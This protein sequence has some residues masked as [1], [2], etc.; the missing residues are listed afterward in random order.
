MKAGKQLNNELSE[1][2]NSKPFMRLAGIISGLPF[3]LSRRTGYFLP[4]N[5]S[6]M[7]NKKRGVTGTEGQKCA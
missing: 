5:E 3:D 6:A 4:K 7:Q 1:G 2:S